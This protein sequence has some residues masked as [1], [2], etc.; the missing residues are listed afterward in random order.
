MASEKHKTSA[1][2]KPAKPGN[3]ASSDEIFIKDILIRCIVGIHPEE[4]EKKQDVLVSL[5][6]EGDFREAARTD[7]IS[8]AINYS[9]LK[10]KVIEFVEASAF[11]LVET[12]A[13]KIADLCLDEP[14]VRRVQVWL[15][16]PTALRFA[17]TVGVHI[18]RP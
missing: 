18:T 3:A 8:Y 4:R 9:T 11:N 15:E 17:R 14:K 2:Q 1:K 13:E 12:L 7:D 5:M 6:L 10:K 16:K